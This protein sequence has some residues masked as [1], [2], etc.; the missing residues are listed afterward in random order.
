MGGGNA[1]CLLILTVFFAFSY[2]GCVQEE[3]GPASVGEDVVLGKK[4]DVYKDLPDCTCQMRVLDANGFDSTWV[5]QE[6]ELGPYGAGTSFSFAGQG[7]QWF[8]GPELESLPSEFR[9]LDP[10]GE[11]CHRF[12]VSLFGSSNQD[13]VLSTEVRCQRGSL[14]GTVE[15]PQFVVPAGESSAWAYDYF[16]CEVILQGEEPPCP[17]V[18]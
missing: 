9:T 17:P 8:S 10:S 1:L 13:F 14:P 6:Y 7:N 12:L 16:S 2:V 11:G 3:V 5:L 18:K 4:G 15:Y